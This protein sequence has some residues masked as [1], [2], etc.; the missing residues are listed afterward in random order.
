MTVCVVS[1]EFLLEEEGDKNEKYREEIKQAN[2]GVDEEW[3]KNPCV[4][5][6]IQ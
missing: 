2:Q 3:N 5:S 4:L 1:I 6:G